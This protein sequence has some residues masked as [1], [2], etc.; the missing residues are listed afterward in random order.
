MDDA[1][2]CHPIGAVSF[3]ADRHANPSEGS[4]L[5]LPRDWRWQAARYHIVIP[6][7]HEAIIDGVGGA[8]VDLVATP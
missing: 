6:S 4:K 2:Q 3:D 7:L 1:Y 5:V 8:S